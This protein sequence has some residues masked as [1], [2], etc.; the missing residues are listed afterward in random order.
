[1]T[2]LLRRRAPSLRRLGWTVDDL[3]RSSHDK[4]LRFLIAP[5]DAA[6]SAVVG[7]VVAVV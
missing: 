3:G 7:A 4:L 1:M 6:E 5:P 2:S